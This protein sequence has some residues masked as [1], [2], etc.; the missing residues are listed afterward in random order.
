MAAAGYPA[1]KSAGG[2]NFGGAATPAFAAV[3]FRS[4]RR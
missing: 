3:F 2:R 1:P 4:L